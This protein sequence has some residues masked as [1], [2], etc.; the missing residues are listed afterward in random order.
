VHSSA[1]GRPYRG[2]YPPGLKVSDGRLCAVQYGLGLG[3]ATQGPEQVGRPRERGPC[4]LGVVAGESG[5]R[6]QLDAGFDAAA[7]PTEDVGESE[8]RLKTTPGSHRVPGQPLGQRKV[9]QLNRAAGRDGEQPR[10]RGKIGVHGEHR[11]A[12]DVLG[13]ATAGIAQGHRDAAT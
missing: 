9:E 1:A 13:A 7:D 2:Q 5:K 11:A 12:Q 6:G 8:L 4:P 3:R 10:V